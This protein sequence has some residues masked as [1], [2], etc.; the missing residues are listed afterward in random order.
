MTNEQMGK[1]C[2]GKKR[3]TTRGFPP[4]SVKVNGIARRATHQLATSCGSS[5]N[6]IPYGG[7][8]EFEAPEDARAAGS[9]E[10]A[11][12]ILC[13]ETRNNTI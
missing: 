2:P 11:A 9:R 12:Y 8:S 3:G 10:P 7:V 4:F 6:I 5:R 1:G 13:R